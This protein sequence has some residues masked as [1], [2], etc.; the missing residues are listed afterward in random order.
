MLLST[1]VKDKSYTDIGL[2]RGRSVGNIFERGKRYGTR[3][4]SLAIGYQVDR[5]LIG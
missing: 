3:G 5:G 1:S 4:V 2:D